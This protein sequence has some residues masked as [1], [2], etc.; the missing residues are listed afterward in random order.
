MD[1]D[2]RKFDEYRE[3][4][5][6][7]VKRAKG[8]ILNS[9][10]DTYSAMANCYGGMI[11]LGVVENED[12]SFTT[13]GLRN[14]DKLRK[15]FWNIVN[16]KQKVSINL[17]TDDDV[18]SYEVSGDIILAIRVSRARREDK[19]VYINDDMF[20]GTFRRNGEGDYH[21]TKAEVKAMLRDQTEETSDMKVLEDMEI[22]DLN[23]ETV[24][25][26]RNR[27][28]T[29]RSEHVWEGL[30]DE[31]YLERIGA[32]KR[33]RADRK[34]HPTAAG[35]LMFGNEFRILYEYPE[36]FLDYREMLDP[37][38]R[39]TDRLQSSSGD[40]SGNLFD[41]FFRVYSKLVKDLKIPFKLEG[42]T[43]ID[44]TPVHKAL[45]E[46]L[47]N[48]LVNTDF[49]VPRGVVIRKDMNKIVIENPGYIRTGK[50]QMLRG[51]ISDPR[52]KALMKMFNMIGI[53][54]RAG[55]GVPDIFAIWNSQGWMTP[56][57]EE[58]YNPGRTIL[59][60]SF[61]EKQAE[62]ASRKSKQKK[63]AEKTSRNGYASKTIE[64][65]QRI[66]DF[67]KKRG[68]SKAVDIA[69]YIGLSSA[70]TRVLLSELMEEGKIKT[71]GNG[72]SRRYLFVP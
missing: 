40:W 9:L 15:D 56:E 8:G 50:D 39:W 41:F 20:K 49:F 47:A 23:M 7:E 18:V 70:R 62:K 19:P 52:N 25:A 1:F 24:H 21:C 48:C 36:Y 17:L 68:S 10:W 30:A 43:R 26:Y 33:A 13:T 59:T 72:R 67:L 37:S 14:V 46:A 27:H 29:Y 5:C 53:G 60:L 38:I 51:G 45:R 11:L 54:E 63:Q 28:I 35:L 4:N 66:I 65:K 16:N 55:S 34:L 22:C 3:N 32:A 2:I 58:Q 57:V 69:E 12:G 6:L 31:E 44:D 61:T 64:N 71:E 42:I